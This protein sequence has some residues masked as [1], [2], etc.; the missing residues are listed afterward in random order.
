[1]S[2]LFGC[3]LIGDIVVLSASVQ[4]ELIA[5]SPDVLSTL[6]VCTSTTKGVEVDE[7]S[8]L[9]VVPECTKQ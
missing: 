4:S 9:S 6:I 8:H 5:E 3:A 1:M 7:V 2:D